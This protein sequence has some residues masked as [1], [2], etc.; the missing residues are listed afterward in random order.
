MI[1]RGPFR[2]EVGLH[3][4]ASRPYDGRDGGGHE[5]APETIHPTLPKNPDGQPGAIRPARWAVGEDPSFAPVRVP[6]DGAVNRLAWQKIF[7]ADAI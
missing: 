7:T 4:I 5:A 3:S 2:Q 1:R 6:A